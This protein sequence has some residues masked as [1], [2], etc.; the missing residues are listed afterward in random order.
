M[1]STDFKWYHL[2][3]NW[4]SPGTGDVES[5]TSTEYKNYYEGLVF[6]FD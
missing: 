6:N 3:S 2:E 4:V 5:M 1:C